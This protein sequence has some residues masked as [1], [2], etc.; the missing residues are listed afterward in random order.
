MGHDSASGLK[1]LFQ[2]PPFPEDWQQLGKLGAA[3]DRRLL[4]LSGVGMGQSQRL[5]PL[6]RRLMPR[7]GEEMKGP[8]VLT[9]GAWE[10]QR[11][12]GWTRFAQVSE[13]GSRRGGIKLICDLEVMPLAT[14]G[15][16]GQSTNSEHS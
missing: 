5:R 1:I 3:A 13:R 8:G 15:L 16:L 9:T 12:S 7:H 10:R 6:K 4:K 11:E 14:A 2:G